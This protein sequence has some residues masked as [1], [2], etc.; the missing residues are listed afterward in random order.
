MHTAPKK[1][2]L[3]FQRQQTWLVGYLRLIYCTAM[4]HLHNH[5]L[6]P[7]NKWAENCTNVDVEMTCLEDKEEFKYF[8]IMLICNWII[9]CSHFCIDVF[10]GEPPIPEVLYRPH[11]DFKCSAASFNTPGSIFLLLL[12]HSLTNKFTFIQKLKCFS[13]LFEVI[14]F[15]ASFR[16]V[17]HIGENHASAQFW[18]PPM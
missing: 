12:L 3:P 13:F 18:I 4:P 16:L 6:L 14:R 9:V 2:H 11:P 17:D 7:W 5:L 15:T 8:F 10:R 1:L